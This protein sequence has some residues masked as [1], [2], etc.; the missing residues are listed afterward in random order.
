[1]SALAAAVGHLDLDGRLRDAFD[2]ALRAA[3]AEAPTVRIAVALGGLPVDLRVTGAALAESLF[4]PFRHL[5]LDAST[6]EAAPVLTI[7]AWSWA[8]TGVPLPRFPADLA[9][10]SADG[11]TSYRQQPG[12]R[13]LADRRAM[14]IL[15]GYEGVATLSYSDLAKPFRSL[16]IPLL[17]DRGRQLLHGGMV[18]PRPGGPGLLLAGRS[19][20]GKSTV[21]LSA[22]AAGLGFLGDDHVCVEL[23]GERFIGHSL[24]GTCGIAP[25]HLPEFAHVP[26]QVTGAPDRAKRV[27]LLASEELP[28]LVR[29]A[30]IG[31]IV[32][33]AIRPGGP[34]RSVRA[35]RGEAMRA[36]MPGSISPRFPGAPSH[37]HRQFEGI[38][39]LAAR[40]PAFR[41]ELGPDL[42]TIPPALRELEAR[43]SPDATE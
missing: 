34:T 30:T 13:A 22:L 39:S 10:C 8:E 4:R 41:L 21:A 35:S 40:L 32:V 3:R 17:H 1:M 19:G 23:E 11:N 12:G 42:A 6:A 43:L 26:G 2:E 29:S 33:P 25:G 9:P 16:L 20:S 7:E 15:A 18:V 36:L 24:Y 31:A 28:R 5:E 14:R 38:A 37:R 27:V